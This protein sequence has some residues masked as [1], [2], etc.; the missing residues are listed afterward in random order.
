MSTVKTR[1]PAHDILVMEDEATVAKGL[2]MVL[3]R[4]AGRHR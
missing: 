3:P 1:Q 4:G 2:E